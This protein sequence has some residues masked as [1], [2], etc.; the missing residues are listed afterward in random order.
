MRFLGLEKAT[1][2][3][4][5]YVATFESDG[6]E[7]HVKFGAKGYTDYTLSNP[8]VREERKRRYLTRHKAREDWSSPDTPG[9]LS[10]WILWNKPTVSA[11]LRDY[12]QRF[13][14]AE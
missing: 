13:H 6:R 3:I 1:D 5:K 12:K 10:R 2:G 14:F 9:A 7:K 8:A 4:H 11:S